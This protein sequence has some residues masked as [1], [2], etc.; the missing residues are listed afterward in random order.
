[1]LKLNL[2][3][4][5]TN[6][7]LLKL[8]EW[9]GSRWRSSQSYL[10]PEVFHQSWS[11]LIMKSTKESSRVLLPETPAR[12]CFQRPSWQG[13]WNNGCGWSR[14]ECIRGP[15]AAGRLSSRL[16]RSPYQAE[17]NV[18]WEAGGRLL[19][20]YPQDMVRWNTCSSPFQ[21][22]PE[23]NPPLWLFL[24][25]ASSS[26]THT[27]HKH[28]QVLELYCS[29]SR[30]YLIKICYF[31]LILMHSLS[32]LV[33]TSPPSVHIAHYVIKRQKFC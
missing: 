16:C 4:N 17:P 7:H 13:L 22:Q 3:I 11:C 29:L 15:A 23:P 21:F 10:G 24:G 25:D 9:W 2:K 31:T 18:E 26:G 27:I 28:E 14:S 33:H 6:T 20:T 1:M 19:S 30:L 12:M 8:S 5:K 32:L